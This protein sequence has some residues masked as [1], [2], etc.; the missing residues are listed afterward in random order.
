MVTLATL[1]GVGVTV[2]LGYWQYG[3]GVTMQEQDATLQRQGSLT[4]LPNAS[5]LALSNPAQAMHRPV[6][7]RGQWLDQRTVFLDNRS[8]AGP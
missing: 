1:L 8:R 2:A 7:L 5:L 6:R 3:R 4:P